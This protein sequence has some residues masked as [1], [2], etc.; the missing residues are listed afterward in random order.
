MAE[1]T[2]LL[3]E[4]SVRSLSKALADEAASEGADPAR[5]LAS[6]N[7]HIRQALAEELEDR[8]AFGTS[9]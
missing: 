5:A 6:A 3:L 9:I 8:R 7:R 1:V 2:S 4:R